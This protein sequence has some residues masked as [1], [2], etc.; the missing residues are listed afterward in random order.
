MVGDQGMFANYQEDNPSQP[1]PPWLAY[2]IDIDDLAH[3]RSVYCPV[4][5]SRSI[6]Q[7]YFA[8]GSPSGDVSQFD[9]SN[10]HQDDCP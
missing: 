4:L 9:G 1:T 5:Q 2:P 6:V 10:G 8:T 7:E 3:S